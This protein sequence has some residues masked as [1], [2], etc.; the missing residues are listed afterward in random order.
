MAD[1]RQVSKRPNLSLRKR[2]MI[3]QPCKVIPLLLVALV[4]ATLSLATGCGNTSTGPSTEMSPGIPQTLKVVTKDNFESVVLNS[5]KPVL[6]DFWAPWCGPCK[7]LMPTMESLAGK[8]DGQ[9]LIAK[10][11][12]DEEPELAEK[13][14]VSSIP[15]LIFFRDGKV[16]IDEAGRTAQ[17]L[18]REIQAVIK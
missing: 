8:Y 1:C 12:T 10:V 4:M 11:N 14:K 17:E 5:D 15:R 3:H 2:K 9:I 18:E 13:F 16:V 7:Q 6:L